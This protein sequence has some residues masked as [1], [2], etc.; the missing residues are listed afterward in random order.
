MAGIGR[1]GT[2]EAHPSPPNAWDR[3]SLHGSLHACDDQVTFQVPA[4]VGPK[5]GLVGNPSKQK[6]VFVDAHLRLQV[7]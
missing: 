6:Y 5:F 7:D 2:G 4:Q 1:I 3:V